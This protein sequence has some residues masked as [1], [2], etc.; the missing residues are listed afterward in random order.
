MARDTT[1]MRIW[2][3]PIRMN[4][5]ISAQPLAQPIDDLMVGPRPMP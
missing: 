1:S 5:A 2:L 3:L 4:T